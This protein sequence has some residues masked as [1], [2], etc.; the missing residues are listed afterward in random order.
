MARDTGPWDAKPVPHPDPSQDPTRG[1][2]YSAGRGN[3]FGSHVDSYTNTRVSWDG[4]GNDKHRGG[5]GGG[6]GCLL[7]SG[8]IAGAGIITAFLGVKYGITT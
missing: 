8:L 4:S 5:S 7:V 1:T 6:G 2:Y 3:T